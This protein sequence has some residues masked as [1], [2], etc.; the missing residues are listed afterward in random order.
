MMDNI[1]K[2]MFVVLIGKMIKINIIIYK[3]YQYH[4][5]SNKLLI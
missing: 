5:M 4:K 1:W 3:W 2:I